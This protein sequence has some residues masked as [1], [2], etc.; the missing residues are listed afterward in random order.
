MMK[1]AF[2]L[3]PVVFAATAWCG[4]F[5]PAY[6]WMW[7]D[8]LEPA[9]LKAQLADMRNHGLTSV[10]IHPWPSRF[11]PKAI[12]TSWMQPEYLSPEYLEI[13]RQVVA[14]AK[15]L[16]MTS[17]LY[18]EGGWP[19]GGAA[20]LVM[21]SDPE[22]RFAVRVIGNDDNRSNELTTK[23][24]PYDAK[25]GR[26]TYPS[27]IE[28]GAT[29]RFLEITHEAYKRTVGEEFGKSIRLAFT[30]EPAPH[31]GRTGRWLGIASDF[32]DEF[33]KRKGYSFAS[34]AAEV[35]S[36][37][38][39]WS[40]TYAR[41]R[42]DYCDVISD[43]FVERYVLPLRAWCRKNGL[44]SSGHFCGDEGPSVSSALMCKGA[45]LRNLRGEDAPGI[46][47]I[48]RQLYP[49]HGF[50]SGD[51]GRQAP[52]PRYAASA[53]RQNGSRYVMSESLGVYGNAIPPHVV[54]WV[55]D[56]QLVRGVNL[57][58]FGYYY[59]TTRG[60][61]MHYLEPTMGPV[62]PWWDMTAPLYRYL[63][64][65]AAFLAAGEAPVRTAVYYD[66]RGFWAG[67]PDSAHACAMHYLIAK[68]LD[69]RPGDYDFVDDETIASASGLERG[70]LC[71]GKARYDTLYVPT[72]K[73]MT[74]AAKAA[75]E[76]FKA[77]GGR[78]LGAEDIAKVNTVCTVTGRDSTDVRATKRLLKN[79]EVRYFLTNESVEWPREVTIRFDEVGAIVRYDP[80]TGQETSLARQPDG[81][82]CWTLAGG[83]SLA[84]R[85]LP[86]EAPAMPNEPVYAEDPFAELK[87]GWT[88]RRVVRHAPGKNDFEIVPVDEEP[89][90]IALG[91]WRATL[92]DDFS[93]KAV[94]RTTYVSATARDVEIDLGRVCWAVSLKVN[95]EELPGHYAAPYRWRIHL[96]KGENVI[97]ATV[98]NLLVNAL[99]E[100]E[101]A[102]IARDYPPDSGYGSKQVEYDRSFQASGLFGPVRLRA[103]IAERGSV[104]TAPHSPQADHIT[105]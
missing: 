8:R 63:E 68:E 15:S 48:W 102:R 38:T 104:P 37:F 90:S 89:R 32:E 23:V 86:G 20:G 18:D 83:G 7:N 35:R 97:E 73:W 51:A 17:W 34:V 16:G 44:L 57:F 80:E 13:Y 24:L 49:S 75:L 36:V 62:Q 77:G 42:I 69:R 1:F 30:D 79:G 93:G 53:A 76:K 27:M 10:C 22:Q 46:D 56:Y 87:E 26:N 6:F 60:G 14:E 99:N 82:I 98:A 101:H 29:E 40:E 65:V 5:S 55:C 25:S 52:I 61:W 78:V 59:Y 19:S 71:I 91:D 92:G 21:D 12:P 72:S 81:S 2:C 45:I 31:T 47:T 54:K 84:L 74:P 50:Q 66:Q 11:R 103:A 41:H 33:R 85:I 9:K 67:G 70:E 3:V 28:P 4:E 39:P 100:R 43:L 94:Y 64:N 58:V 105:P 88:V 96:N 95:G